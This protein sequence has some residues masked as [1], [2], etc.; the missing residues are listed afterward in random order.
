MAFLV[1]FLRLA[2][3]GTAIPQLGHDYYAIMGPRDR[4]RGH[5]GHAAAAAPDD[6]TRNDPLRVAAGNENGSLRAAECT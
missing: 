6:G 5:H 2:P 3:A 1:A 4:V